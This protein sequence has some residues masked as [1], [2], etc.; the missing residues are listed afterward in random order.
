MDARTIINELLKAG[1]TRKQIATR[2]QITTAS[3]S[4]ILLGKVKTIHRQTLNGL[5]A[6]HAAV[7]KAATKRL[8]D[9]LMLEYLAA[10]ELSSLRLA[11]SLR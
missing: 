6:V 3:V 9:T 8:D 11:A 4:N 2:A 7:V 1:L 5:L 10:M